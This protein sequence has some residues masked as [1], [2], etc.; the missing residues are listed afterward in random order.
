VEPIQVDVLRNQAIVE[1]KT[2]CLT[3]TEST[4][5]YVL[6]VNAHAVCTANQI[7]SSLWGSGNDGGTHLMK[8]HIRH[9]RQKIEPDPSHPTSHLTVSGVG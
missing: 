1:G 2:V 4:L 3:P 7:I 6:A 9:V 5:L 8:G